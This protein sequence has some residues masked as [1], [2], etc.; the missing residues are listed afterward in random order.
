GWQH[1][2]PKNGQLARDFSSEGNIGLLLGKP[3]QWLI[4]ID[5]D[6]P[7][8][9]RLAA[10]FLPATP[11]QSGRRSAPL[12]HWWYQCDIKTEKFSDPN[13]ERGKSDKTRGMIV[14]I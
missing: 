12:S 14:E 3:S 5:L 8:A 7:E 13:T 10:Q 2:A 9:Q 6:W 4:D 11:M 1:Y